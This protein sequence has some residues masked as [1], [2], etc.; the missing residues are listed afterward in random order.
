M[1]WTKEQI[2]LKTEEKNFICNRIG[3]LD[4]LK[5]DA[6]WNVQLC[7]ERRVLKAKF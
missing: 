6:S 3:A 1:T 2:R 4:A 7:E 5:G